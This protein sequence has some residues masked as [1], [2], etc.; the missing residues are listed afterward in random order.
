MRHPKEGDR[1]RGICQGCRKVVMTRYWP[2]TIALTEPSYA[3]VP[4]VLVA[5]CEECWR[6]VSVPH[7]STPQINKAR[8][9]A[10]LA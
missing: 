3:E 5:C 10:R 7:Q 1:S 6:I 2:R 9:L 8:R 4:N